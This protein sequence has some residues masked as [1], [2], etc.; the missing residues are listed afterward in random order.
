WQAILT[1]IA[2]AGVDGVLVAGEAG[3]YRALS[4][5]ERV[6]VL[7]FCRQALPREV[8]VYGNA[9]A[10]TT[11]ESVRLAQAAEAEG[12]DCVAVTAPE[13]DDPEHYIEICR[14]VPIPVLA[15]GLPAASCR[16]VAA[17]CDNFLGAHDS[18]PSRALLPTLESGYASLV[19]ACAAVAPGAVVE[20]YKSWRGARPA[21]AA[22][23]AEM[24]APLQVETASAVKEAMR[25]A[26]CPAGVC[27]RPAPAVGP[28]LR[29][30]IESAI[31]RL[32][33]ARFLPETATSA[34][35]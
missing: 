28:D 32:R 20:L 11:R 10:S 5:E 2:F 9:G 12:I 18:T 22:R 25:L 30:E 4:E 6:V 16:R 24:L 14:A 31:A 1:R 29:R 3:E 27:R 7:R 17:A 34:S 26:G 21:D 15:Q 33:A 8:V 23:L 19:T 13:V 35:P